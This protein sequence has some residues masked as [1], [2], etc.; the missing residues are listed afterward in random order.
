MKNLRVWLLLVLAV[1]I[2]VRGAMAAAMGCSSGPAGSGQV[3]L[4]APSHAKMPHAHEHA[5]M[6]QAGAPAAHAGDHPHPDRHDVS[7]PC[8][9]CSADC[10]VTPLV[11][12]VPRLPDPRLTAAVV[13][14]A[15]SAPVPS[16]LSDGPERPPRSS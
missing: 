1:L 11:S 13:F 7:T 6:A 5:S 12:A 10:S 8:P 16:F 3:R 14:P 2:P 15:A 4:A 9:M